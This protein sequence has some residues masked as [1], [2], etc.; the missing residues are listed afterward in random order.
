MK[1]HAAL[2]LVIINGQRYW[3]PRDGQRSVPESDGGG[4]LRIAAVMIPLVAL[5][6]ALLRWL[7]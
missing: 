7:R 4:L 1:Y 5:A 2:R 3:L 6:L